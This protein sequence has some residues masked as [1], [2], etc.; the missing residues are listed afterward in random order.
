M[1]V[2]LVEKPGLLTTVQDLGR[3]GHRA[4]GVPPSGALDRFALAAAN[5]L[6]GNPEGAAGLECALNGPLLLALEPC[7]IAV[8]GADFTPCVNGGEIPLWTGVYLAAGER[9]SFSGRRGGARCYVAVAGGLA[10]KRWLGS[11]STYLLVEKGGF[12]G[13]T[14]E[15]GDEL[16]LAGTPPRPL[17]SGRHLSRRLLPDYGREPVLAALPGPHYA[18]LARASRTA[19]WKSSFEVT[20][21]ADRMGF[22]LD[23]PQLE[24]TGR[25]LLSL[26]LTMGAVQLPLGGQPILLMADHQTAGGYPVVVGVARAALPLAAQ[27]LPGDRLSFAEVGLAEAQD[28]WR[29]LRRSL[30][31]IA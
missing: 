21:D 19:L 9:L 17:V 8:T 2:L 5:R 20:R 18:R 6:V 23:G 11:L 14:L 24:V 29:R 31:E 16:E 7:L 22:R 28:A 12:D 10:G 3:P 13:R 27:L 4:F 26:G 15:A 25:E 1:A 30:E